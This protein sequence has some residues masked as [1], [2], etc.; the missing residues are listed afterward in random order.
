MENTWIIRSMVEFRYDVVKQKIFLSEVKSQPMNTS[1]VWGSFHWF[2]AGQSAPITFIGYF[3]KS[4]Q[5]AD[6]QLWV[7]RPLTQ[8]TWA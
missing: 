8:N 4:M 6:E 1:L 2:N 5:T 3:P 7:S